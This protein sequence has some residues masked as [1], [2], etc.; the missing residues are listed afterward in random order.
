M[1]TLPMLCSLYDV[2]LFLSDLICCTDPSRYHD[3]D[4]L[5]NTTSTY[6]E[7]VAVFCAFIFS[8]NFLPKTL[9]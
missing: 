4:L 6:P 3:D 1:S 8:L 2:I 9:I 7:N 5:L